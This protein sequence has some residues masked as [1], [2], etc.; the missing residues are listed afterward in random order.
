MMSPHKETLF[1]LSSLHLQIRKHNRDFAC[2]KIMNEAF[3]KEPAYLQFSGLFNQYVILCKRVRYHL[4][5]NDLE[6]F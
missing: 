5:M 4:F 6:S 3:S 1:L 2:Y